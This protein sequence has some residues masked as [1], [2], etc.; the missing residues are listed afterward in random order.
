ME[1]KLKGTLPLDLYTLKLAVALAGIVSWVAIYSRNSVI[2][3]LKEIEN[4]LAMTLKLDGLNSNST[5]C[6]T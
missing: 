5:Q 1:E 2:V 3:C 6:L 4:K